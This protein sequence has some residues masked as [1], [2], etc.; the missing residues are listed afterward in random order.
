MKGITHI[1][2]RWADADKNRGEIGRIREEVQT[3]DL[4][5]RVCIICRGILS[6]STNG[7]YEHVQAQKMHLSR[8]YL[9]VQKSTIE[10]LPWRSTVKTN[11]SQGKVSF[12]CKG[13]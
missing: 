5:S 11:K 13:G 1:Y 4:R 6:N 9:L 2:W 3:F 8:I 12:I 7:L 10:R